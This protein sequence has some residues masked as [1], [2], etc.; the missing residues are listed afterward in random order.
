[1]TTAVDKGHAVTPARSKRLRVPV[2]KVAAI[3]DQIVVSLTN[4]VLAIAMGRAF[5]A[6]EFAS[7]GIGLSIGL[8]V[9]GLQRHAV[10][11]PLMLRPADRIARRHRAILAEQ[12]WLVLAVVTVGVLAVAA[13]W[14]MNLG[15]YGHLIALSSL[16]SLIVYLQLEFSRTFLVKTGRPWFL[17]ASA[18]WYCVVALALAGAALSHRIGYETVLFV[19][20][21]AMALHALSLMMIAGSPQWSRGWRLLRHDIRRYGGWSA[22]ATLTYSGYNHVPLLLLGAL[23]AP[24]HA[25]V[26]VATRSLMQP[27]QIIQRGLDIAD[28][29]AFAGVARKP[30]ARETLKLILTFS[31]FYMLIGVVYCAAA[32]LLANDLITLAYGSKFSD[33]ESALFAWLP[34]YVLMGLSL[35]LETLVYARRDFRHYFLLRGLAS[36]VAIALSL[37]LLMMFY[38]TGAIAACAAGWL[39]AALGTVIRLIRTTP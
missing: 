26:F 3:G 24:V 6:E 31:A 38:E 11:I 29:S 22:A 30:Y 20:G 32:G 21:G 28:K 13:A 16:V 10:T 14:H 12:Y 23:A 37:P 1:M 15:R 9:Q 34:V 2:V 5:S 25:A 27:L 7:F 35:P 8:M 18:G 19:L 17:I 4:F 33:A 39:L 36:V